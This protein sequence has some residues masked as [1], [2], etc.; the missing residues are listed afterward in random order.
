MNGER[1]YSVGQLSQRFQAAPWD[2]RQAAEELHLEPF[3]VVNDVEHF[4][5]ADCFDIGKYLGDKATGSA[6]G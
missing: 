4:R 3:L 6:R 2:I 5:A 1:I